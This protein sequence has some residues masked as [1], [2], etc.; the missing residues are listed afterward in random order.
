MKY[1]AVFR[2]IARLPLRQRHNGGG[3]AIMVKPAVYR[4]LGLAFILTNRGRAMWPAGKEEFAGAGILNSMK[5]DQAS[6]L[7]QA[8]VGGAIDRLIVAVLL[9]QVI[10]IAKGTG[11]IS[12]SADLGT[13]DIFQHADGIGNLSA[14]L[15]RIFC[16]GSENSEYV[17]PFRRGQLKLIRLRTTATL[18]NLECR[19]AGLGVIDARD[20]F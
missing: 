1:G 11:A 18:A 15:C 9:V 12:S 3:M 8:H 2:D 5:A 20:I 19:Q 6:L 16:L 7:H 17:I 14:F 10:A 4:K 13:Y